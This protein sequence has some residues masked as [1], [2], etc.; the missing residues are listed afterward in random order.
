MKRRRRIGALEPPPS[1]DA[2]TCCSSW[3]RAAR[4]R[5]YR[6]GPAPVGGAPS[7][8]WL[9]PPYGWRRQVRGRVRPRSRS[10][11]PRRGGGAEPH[12]QQACDFPSVSPT[13]SRLRPR[14][15]VSGPSMLVAAA[16]H[17][18]EGPV[19]EG[20][21][22]DHLGVAGFQDH[23]GRPAGQV[24]ARHDGVPIRIQDLNELVVLILD[25]DVSRVRRLRE[26]VGDGLGST[27]RGGPD[28]VAQ[29]PFE[30]R[31]HGDRCDDERDS[32]HDDRRAGSAH[33]MGSMP[34]R[35]RAQ[36]EVVRSPP[37]FRQTVPCAA[38]GLQRPG[39]RADRACCGDVRCRPRRCSGLPRRRSPIRDRGSLALTP[40][41]PCAA[42]GIRGARPRAWSGPPGHRLSTPVARP[43]EP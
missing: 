21:G 17:R 24:G 2:P 16:A 30:Q 29:R 23:E 22:S 9:P 14:T 39:R 1:P 28:V 37:I 13:P 19:L 31:Q 18:E 12:G 6:A 41:H 42:T 43:V 27:V 34:C 5:L 11:S 35:M 3:R 7:P 15:T 26:V 25:G 32:D 40:R 38:H 10:R 36:R 8:R 33:P 20:H 4:S